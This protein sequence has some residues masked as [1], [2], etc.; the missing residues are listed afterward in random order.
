MRIEGIVHPQGSSIMISRVRRYI[1]RHTMADPR[2]PL[3]VGVSGGID[4]MVL[5]HL[6]QRLGHPVS[7]VHV[8]HGLRGEESEADRMFVE[9]F[10]DQ[11]AIPFVS[12]T[13]N[14]VVFKEERN[15]SIQMAARELRYRIFEE[16]QAM[17][18]MKIALAHHADDAIETLMIELMRGTGLRGWRTIP[19]V[20]GTVIRPM[21]CLSREEILEYAR[22]HGIE[23]REDSSNTQ[24]KYLRN[25]VRLELLPLMEQI[26][27]GTRRSL[28]RSVELLREMDVAM[29]HHLAGSET[30]V[31]RV[32]EEKHIPLASILSSG[33]PRAFL[34][35]LL[36]EHGFHPDRIDDLLNASEDKRIGSAF[37]GES[38]RAIVDREYLILSPIVSGIREWTIATLEDLPADLPYE[39]RV[40]DVKDTKFTDGSG[41]HWLAMEKVQFPLIIRPWRSGDRM[42]P[43]GM[44]GSKLISDILIDAKI[45][46]TGKE[47][48]YVIESNG[49]I[50]V[51]IGHRISEDLKVD[52]GTRE[53]LR[54]GVAARA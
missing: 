26:R 50:A 41:V 44:R 34:L 7:V 45:S 27:A 43:L 53:V 17:R 52:E 4:S 15:A 18:P 10:C 30:G 11:R 5:L 42:R 25:R 39:L 47:R 12:R 24:L 23:H 9:A 16:V 13:V 51:L 6:L 29:Q 20:S 49:R 38:I 37:I 35:H 36:R 19:P 31:V 48:T 3:W 1:L 22:R 46:L 8:D 14:V 33:V 40:A 2:E 28:A 21:L 54:V 32:G